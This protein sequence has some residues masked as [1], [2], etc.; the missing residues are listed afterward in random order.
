ML[1]WHKELWLIDH[2][3]SLYFHHNWNDIED[4]KRPFPGIRNHVLL[5]KATELSK[6]SEELC[7]TLT[8]DKIRSIVAMV[9]DEFLQDESSTA[10]AEKYREAYATFL[11]G[12]I[13]HADFFVN[14]ANE[15][16]K[17][18]V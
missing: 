13:A 6:I 9:P 15:A 16:R 5:S 7:S 10:S 12:R 11:E 18:L 17:L 14:E 8:R 1:M 2:G 4:P 3:A